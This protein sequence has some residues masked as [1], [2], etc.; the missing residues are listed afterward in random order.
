MLIIVMLISIIGI[1]LCIINDED[2]A[3]MVFFSGLAIKI[4]ILAI[5]LGKIINGRVI[6]QKI[7]LIENQNKDIESKIE[8]TVKKYMDFEK[9]TYIELTTDSY[10]QLV[11]LY[12]NLKSDTLIQEQIKIY[13]ENNKSIIELKKEK[14]DISNYKW[15]VYFGK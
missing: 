4:L 6:D 7:E 3:V 2:E 10:I 14:I 8:I 15:W 1:I 13:E 12:P 11:N 9:E 5:L